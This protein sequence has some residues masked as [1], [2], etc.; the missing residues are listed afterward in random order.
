MAPNMS[1]LTGHATVS[2][3]LFAFLTVLPVSLLGLRVAEGT[4]VVDKVTLSA[5]SV[6]CCERLEIT[7]TVSGQFDNPFDP[8]QIQV[9]GQ[10]RSPEGK[11]VTMP[12]FL[13]QEFRRSLKDGQEAVEPAGEPVWKVRFAPT[14]P[15][16][17]SCRIVA[18]DKTGA[19]ESPR[20]E[21]TA[22]G[23][24]RP[25]YIRRSA[26]PHYF[27]YDDGTPFF[28]IGE[29]VAWS[30]KR[31]TY[32]FDD[33]LPAAGKA[34]MNLVRIWL[35]WNRF[36]SIEHKG[37]GAGRYDLGN[38]WRM[39]YVLDLARA[40]GLR[41]LFTCD[42][43]EP[44]QKEHYWLGK[45]TGRPWENC[46]HNVINGGPLKEPDE[47]YTTEEGHRLIRQ[48]LRYIVARWG[49]DPNIFCWELWNELNC[50]PGWTKLVPEIVRWHVEMAE[51]LRGLDP[52][53]HLITTSFGNPEGQEDIWRSKGLD[54]V[55][56]HVYGP[57]DMAEDL[58]AITRTMME[59]Y[60]QPHVT[61]EFG[62]PLRADLM[63]LP[64][65]DPKGIYL[66]N[67]VWS[68]A[69]SGAASC[70]LTWW[71]DN[72][73]H[74]CNLYGIFTALAQFCEGVPWTTAGFQTARAE[75]A[76]VTPPPPAQPEPLVID[77][78]SYWGQITEDRFVVERNGVVQGKAKVCGYLHGS[79]HQ[80][81]RKPP[82]FVV[83]YPEPGK[84]I[85]HVD[86]VDAMGILEI[87]V[88]GQVVL[89]KELPAGEGQGPWK[90]SKLVEG[91]G[92]KCWAATYDQDF[93]VHVPAG[94]HEIRLDNLGKDA[95][96][97]D[98][99]TLTNYRQYVGPP[100]RCVGL[101]GRGLALIWVQNVMHTWSRVYQGLPVR[102]V[103]GAKLVLEGI[104]DGACRIEWWDTWAG[105]PTGE[106]SA[107]A[108]GGKL[109][110]PLPRIETDLAFKVRWQ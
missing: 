8:R 22:T 47:F 94:R 76:W 67:G 81:L 15:G 18:K 104:P 89:S 7:F 19:A 51:T 71:W 59:R 43:P 32:D 50:F 34:K 46:P 33:W 21:F 60:G 69:L 107:Q 58:P 110:V 82:T 53:G 103:E 37:T 79:T 100:L 2:S 86:K 42:S 99:I 105:K 63:K 77:P 38:A 72:Y 95:I 83:D 65:V 68:T 44:Y 75:T 87:R 78:V 84:F 40:N 96:V 12:A 41:V 29:N 91:E 52:N 93:A 26:D 3:L 56:S 109:T 23:E 80:G 54:F 45:L 35:Q 27:R 106:T 61:G 74:P 85:A 98:R 24:V 30:G 88:D 70:A 92:W 57:K 39:D 64:Q 73:V 97:L 5:P 66:H 13:Y 55:Q 6:G 49:W 28:G 102:P 1:A 14:A 31:G 17:W 90:S 48:R 4:P 9:D 20:Q 36:L 62:P 16:A 108:T 25:G 10:F 11:E 101:T